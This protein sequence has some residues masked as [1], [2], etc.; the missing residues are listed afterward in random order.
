M[1]YGL[2]YV[3]C[4]FVLS[5]ASSHVH[6]LRYEL[7]SSG[8]ASDSYISQNDLASGLF[9]ISGV[10]PSDAVIK[11][12]SVRFVFTDDTDQINTRTNHHETSRTPFVFQES[13]TEGTT[14]RNIYVRQ[15]YETTRGI[16]SFDREAVDVSLGD[17]LFVGTASPVRV[18]LSERTEVPV[19]GLVLDHQGESQYVVGYPCE[20]H[21]CQPIFGTKL[22]QYYDQV[23]NVV[24]KT[25]YANEHDFSLFSYITDSSFLE[26]LIDDQEIG[27]SLRVHGEEGGRGDTLF[28][29]AYLIIETYDAN[30]IPEPST[31][32]LLGAGFLW[33]ARRRLGL[34]RN[35]S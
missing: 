29:A 30:Q 13:V 7:F 33:F 28:S 34:F 12:A 21:H 17:G 27:F 15:R 10:L 25:T 6:A 20:D 19:D 1:K 4:A 5:L 32:L 26:S 24:D 23:I 22:H 2:G 18:T 3:V 14:I 16:F 35:P 8:L 31:G 11:T 9:D